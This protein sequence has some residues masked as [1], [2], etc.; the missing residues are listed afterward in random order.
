MSG[1]ELMELRTIAQGWKNVAY[2]I[3]GMVPNHI[4]SRADTLADRAL[5]IIGEQVPEQRS[6]VN[7]DA[8]PP[9]VHPVFESA[10]KPFR[11]PTQAEEEA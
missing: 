5:D 6:H 4:W 9:K 8:D 3:R 7:L 1:E 10:L 11:P 2:L